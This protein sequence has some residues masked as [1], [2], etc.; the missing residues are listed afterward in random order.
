[1]LEHDLRQAEKA[2]PAGPSEALTRR[3][4]SEKEIQA[5]LQRHLAETET[6]L[7]ELAQP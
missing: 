4:G 5:K 3:I 1:M 6:R 2:A 7:A